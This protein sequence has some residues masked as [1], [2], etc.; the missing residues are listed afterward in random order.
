M[1][2]LL[3]SIFMG[4]SLF[5][6]TYCHADAIYGFRNVI[7][8]GAGNGVSLYMEVSDAALAAGH[9]NFAGSSASKDLLAFRWS[10]SMLTGY[11]LS[12]VP[13]PYTFLNV[14]LSFSPNGLVTGS[15]RSD[16]AITILDMRSDASGLFT[17][18]RI[19]YNDTRVYQCQI[20]ACPAFPTGFVERIGTVPEPGSFALLA[21][22]LLGMTVIVRRKA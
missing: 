16:D 19:G 9:L 1:K 3:A 2:K 20:E 14:N 5:A 8:D 4:A 22:A 15:I 6:S 18:Q 7:T 21:V 11:A 10:S 12:P 13:T 17:T